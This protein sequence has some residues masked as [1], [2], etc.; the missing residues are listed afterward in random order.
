MLSLIFAFQN[1]VA[2][3][4]FIHSLVPGVTCHVQ[5]IRLKR[6]RV[7]FKGVCCLPH[8]RGPL[9]PVSSQHCWWC[10]GQ[11]SKNN[12]PS[13]FCYCLLH[14]NPSW[15][16]PKQVVIILLLLL[17]NQ[18]MSL[19]S[20]EG[21]VWSEG[22]ALFS[23]SHVS[24]FQ[25]WMRHWKLI[26]RKRPCPGNGHNEQ[27]SKQKSHEMEDWLVS[28]LCEDVWRDVGVDHFDIWHYTVSLS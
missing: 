17:Y 24:G 5:L 12:E 23:C 18:I 14:M 7:C 25:P 21:E 4:L 2:T 11:T 13:A 22:S 26:G 27:H 28:M 9:L 10:V 8:I 15:V 19:Q 6:W 3:P 20:C 1:P 16:V